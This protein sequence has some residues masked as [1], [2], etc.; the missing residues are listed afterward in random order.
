M[1]FS[2]IAWTTNVFYQRGLIWI[3]GKIFTIFNLFSLHLHVMWNQL[4]HKLYLIMRNSRKRKIIKENEIV[5]INNQNQS[6][7]AIVS[8]ILRLWNILHSINNKWIT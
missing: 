2:N 6:F 7:N 1:R 4:P 5:A 8:N 3:P